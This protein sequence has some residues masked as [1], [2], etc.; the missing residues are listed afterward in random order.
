MNLTQKVSTSKTKE[1]SSLASQPNIV[2]VS[3]EERYLGNMTQ[4]P[5][6][7]F[8]GAIGGHLLHKIS[9]STTQGIL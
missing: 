6:I 9:S 3:S 2:S 4:Q 5:H 7:T 8:S 1:A